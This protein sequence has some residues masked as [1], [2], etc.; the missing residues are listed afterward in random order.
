MTQFHSFKTIPIYLEIA[1]AAGEHDFW[2]RLKLDTTLT[3]YAVARHLELAKCS[4]CTCFFLQKRTFL[5]A[6]SNDNLFVLLYKMTTKRS[7]NLKF[8]E[9]KLIS[10]EEFCCSVTESISYIRI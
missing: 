7:G 5:A 6:S 4:L 3:W 8:V 2:S 1:F 9:C 10:V